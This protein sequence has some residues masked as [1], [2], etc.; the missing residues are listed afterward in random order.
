ML[1]VSNIIL[2]RF[3]DDL[4]LLRALVV[5]FDDGIVPS[6]A[7]VAE[8]DLLAAASS[9]A[10][11]LLIIFASSPL[12]LL[13]LLFASVGEDDLP[14]LIINYIRLSGRL[15]ACRPKRRW[16][17]SFNNDTIG[18]LYQRCFLAGGQRV[19]G[20]SIVPMMGGI[21][22]SSASC[23]CVSKRQTCGHDAFK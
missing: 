22:G 5:F 11:L 6:A 13:L 9:P 20:R 23:R 21:K 16:M 14:T 15:L 1:L 19:G 12:L 4:L 17:A 8:L 2:V 18:R 10:S 3:D 7:A